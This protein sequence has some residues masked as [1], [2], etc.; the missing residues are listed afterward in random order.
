MVVGIVE[1]MDR[2]VMPVGED[3][4][5]TFV[6]VHV[7][8]MLFMFLHDFVFF[9]QLGHGVEARFPLEGTDTTAV[10]TATTRGWVCT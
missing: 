6:A 5:S 7:W 9:A 2:F 8:T 3:G 10:M 4:R 1:F